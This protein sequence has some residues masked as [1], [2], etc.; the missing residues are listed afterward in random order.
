MA[1]LFP[2]AIARHVFDSW[3]AIIAREFFQLLSHRLQL[4]NLLQAF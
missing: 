1:D 4:L 2:G 3:E